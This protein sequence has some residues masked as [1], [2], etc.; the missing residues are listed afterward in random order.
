MLYLAAIARVGLFGGDGGGLKVGEAVVGSRRQGVVV[1]AL[2][3]CCWW[4]ECRDVVW[5]VKR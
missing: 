4:V 5:I 1:V 3:V 2:C